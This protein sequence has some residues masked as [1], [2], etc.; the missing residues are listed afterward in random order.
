MCLA[1][2]HPAG[3]VLKAGVE[4]KSPDALTIMPNFLSLS[5]IAPALSEKDLHLHFYCTIS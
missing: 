1:E 3:F 5:Q 2:D 4:L